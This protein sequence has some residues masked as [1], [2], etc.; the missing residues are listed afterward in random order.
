M[1]DP[2]QDIQYFWPRGRARKSFMQARP[3]MEF[4]GMRGIGTPASNGWYHRYRIRALRPN[5][6]PVKFDLWPMGFTEYRIT[7]A[8]NPDR[9]R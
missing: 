8:I 6:T 5:G 2:G 9:P 4:V 3:R 1:P 7:P